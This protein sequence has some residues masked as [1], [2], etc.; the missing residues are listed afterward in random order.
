MSKISLDLQNGILQI[1]L[2]RPEKGNAID[3]EMALQLVEAFSSASKSREAR[4]VLLRGRGRHFCAGADLS[5]LGDAQD[6]SVI[7]RLYSS[8]LHCDLPV[9]ALGHGSVRGGGVGLMAAS[10]IA[11]CD[12]ATTF[13]LPEIF[14]GLSPGVLSPALMRKI[15]YSRFL[16]HSLS[17]REFSAREAL[18][19]GLVNFTGTM[20]EAEKFLL[21]LAGR[22]ASAPPEAVR[23][24]KATARSLAPISESTLQALV[25]SNVA[26]RE[27][28]ETKARIAQF[29]ERSGNGN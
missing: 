21:E 7:S 27:S 28:R 13:G 25:E 6:L 2:S 12:A 24:I 15:G 22:I 11:A 16:E 1:T 10:D 9:L 29:F 19:D 8:I 3:G 20:A 26:L 5:W 4:L 18:A 14:L 23:A 17:G